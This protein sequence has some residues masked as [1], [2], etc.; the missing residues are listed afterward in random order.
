[1]SRNRSFVALRAV[2]GGGAVYLALAASGLGTAR[3]ARAE[4]TP[5]RLSAG[6]LHTC[7]VRPD[8]TVWCWGRNSSGQLGDGTTVDKLTPVPVASLSNV[9]EVSVGAAHSCARKSDGTVWCWGGNGDGQLG[10][11]TT[12]DRLTPV[13]AGR[14]PAGRRQLAH[15]CRN[16]RR[17]CCV[18][19]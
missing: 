5:V 2:A 17:R 10:D 15:L 19:G 11:G 7:A 16:Q 3:E 4:G 12:A 13:V 6:Y 1:M 8:A 14:G 18:L 9:V